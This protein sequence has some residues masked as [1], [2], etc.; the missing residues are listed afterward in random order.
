MSII[1]KENLE[2][3]KRSYVCRLTVF[4][5]ILFGIFTVIFVINGALT[6]SLFFS[7]IRLQIWQCSSSATLL[8]RT[9]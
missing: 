8:T 2:K 6:I 9:F 1:N 7:M 4:S 5:R 3:K